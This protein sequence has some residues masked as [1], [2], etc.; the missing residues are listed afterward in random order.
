M[1]WFGGSHSYPAAARV[2]PDAAFV[3]PW[4]HGNPH[5]VR[6]PW[7][8]A[9]GQS[10]LR[11]G[12]PAGSS[13]SIRLYPASAEFEYGAKFPAL[14][15]TPQPGE[16]VRASIVNQYLHLVFTCTTSKVR[17][18]RPPLA[19]CLHQQAPSPTVPRSPSVLVRLAPPQEI[20]NV[21]FRLER[22][23]NCVGD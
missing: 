23:T 5:I 1:P 16:I 11:G 10:K 21:A 18:S 12:E 19:F 7:L 22:F 13:I 6:V 14:A 20:E 9:L 2:R 8:F 4:N 15:P 17:N 3:Q